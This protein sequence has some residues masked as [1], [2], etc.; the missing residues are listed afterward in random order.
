MK[1]FLAAAAIVL[2]ASAAFAQANDERDVLLTQGGT[3]YTVESQLAP[4][5]SDSRRQLVLTVQN[6]DDN[7]TT[8][9][10]ESL[11]AG[12]RCAPAL[13]YDAESNTLFVF[14]LR[15]PNITS[16]ELLLATY[17]DGKWSTPV[18]VDNKGFRLRSN[19]RIAV[20][21]QVAD[22]A[23][24]DAPA[25][26]V[27]AVW[28]EQSSGGEQARYA[29]VAIDKGAVSAVEVHDLSEFQNA[30]PETAVVDANFNS[31][32]LRH[33]AILDN[34][35]KDSIDVLFGDIRSNTFSRTTLKPIAQ[36]RI[37]IPIG[38]SGGGPDR[39]IAAPAMFSANWSGRVSAIGAPNGNFLLY[40]TTS[41]SVRYIMFDD[42]AW[43]A[44]RS[45]PVSDKLTTDGAVS[46]LS[47]M[48]NQ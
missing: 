41:D 17:H 15:M 20:T 11:T 29:L 38:H 31:E 24:V 34:G 40:N 43:T 45:V 44:V 37:H 28:W 6:G 30:A 13:T 22:A 4:A 2:S 19:L 21:R 12:F 36:G 18:S 16:S 9:V 7:Q 46:V 33:P 5:D 48:L 10:P 23:N 8:V 27:H 14:W 25:L 3:L 32:I 1:R 42:G 47:R 26:I 35:S 39:V